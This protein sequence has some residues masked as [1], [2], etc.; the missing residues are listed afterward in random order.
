MAAQPYDVCIIGGGPAGLTLLSAIHDQFGVLS[1]H[2]QGIELRRRR[3]TSSDASHGRDAPIRV[4]VVDPA[5]AFLAD[6]R[7]RFDAL[8]IGFLRSPAWAHPDFYSPNA[9]CEYAWRKGRDA[10]LRTLDLSGSSLKHLVELNA[11]LFRL[12]GA[13]LYEDFC[14]DLAK[15]LPHDMVRGVA[16]KIT[17]ASNVYDVAITQQPSVRA[18]SVVFALGA[19]MTPRAPPEFPLDHPLVTHTNDWRSLG[20]LAFARGDTVLVIG[21]GLSA[22]QAA[23]RAARRG[24]GRVVACSRRPLS[25]RHYDLDLE[26][27]N[28]RSTAK[29]NARGRLFAFQGKPLHERRAWVKDARGGGATVPPSYVRDLEAAAERGGFERRV[30]EAVKV[31]D[32]DGK[33]RVTFACG[34]PVDATRVILAT[35][36]EF[37]VESVPLLATAAR[38]FNLPVVDGLPALDDDLAW[39]DERFFVVGALATLQVGP[40]AGNLTGARRAADVCAANLGCHDSLVEKGSILTNIYDVFGDSDSSDE[41][42]DDDDCV[43]TVETPPSS[44]SASS[45]SSSDLSEFD[46]CQVTCPSPE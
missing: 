13:T 43:A 37:D 21:G 10:E 26:W 15:T 34:A 29:G 9:L 19:A 40:D 30:D 35:G 14:A 17:K 12:P 8:D 31:E 32:V 38:D 25:E 39:G 28:P 23:L 5:G 46:A 33:L 22:A 7:G 41:S 2:Q 1:D 42:D 11:G 45:A 3:S 27:M 18:K 20:K 44:R 4:C 36:S 6:W 16:S 24:A